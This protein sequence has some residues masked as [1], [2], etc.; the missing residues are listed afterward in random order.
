MSEKKETIE[1]KL[2]QK[3]KKGHFSLFV[4]PHL[5]VLRDHRHLH[6]RI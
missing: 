6:P 1:K 4:T 5:H 2:K 3:Q